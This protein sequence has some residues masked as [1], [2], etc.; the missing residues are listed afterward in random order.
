MNKYIGGVKL[1]NL[2]PFIIQKFYDELDALKKTESYAIGKPKLKNIM[3]NK[4][5]SIVELSR[6]ANTALNCI[7]NS[8]NGV[9]INIK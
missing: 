9:R 5:L 1:K 2:T 8:I 4:G 7:H 3:D 6:R